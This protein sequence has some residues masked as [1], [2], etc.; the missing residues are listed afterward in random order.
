[1][2]TTF[3]PPTLDEIH[4]TAARIAPYIR[5]TPVVRWN[6]DR[7]SST[8]GED[9][10][11]DLKLELLQRTGTF[12]ARGF[13]NVLALDHDQRRRGIT[14]I[15]AG[16]HAIAAAYA[17]HAVGTTA[18]VVM[19]ATANPAR[20]A[21][22]RAFGAEVLMAEDGPTGF[23]MVDEIAA[24]E[25]RTLVH[26][27]EGPRVTEGTATCGLELHEAIDDLDAIVVAI[28]AGGLCSGLGTVTRLLKPACKIYGVEPTGA[29]VMS[30]SLAAGSAQSVEHLDTI[31][32]S[33]A[34]PMTTP[35]C[36]AMCQ[37][38][39]EEVVLVSD[40]EMAAA[41]A[42]LF[43]HMNLAVEPAGAAATAAAFGPLRQRLAGKRSAIV[44]CG[45]NIDAAGFAALIDRGQRGLDAGVLA[46]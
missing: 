29:P 6:D 30:R 28:G 33:L 3:N 15:S 39:L 37:R 34:P 9:A 42:L 14:A 40:D 43:D 23:A 38:A 2:P 5:H 1:M 36:F 4:A 27:F 44:I 18:K 16:N 21:A 25:G 19:L 35:Y 46:V 22:A 20:V 24:G 41:A 11:V 45:S 10:R 17:A 31:A 7:I 26:P 32:D 8:L 13:N 12:K